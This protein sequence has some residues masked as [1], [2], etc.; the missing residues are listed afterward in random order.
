MTEYRQQAEGPP[1]ANRVLAPLGSRDNPLPF[2]IFKK[3][4]LCGEAPMAHYGIISKSV[5]QHKGQPLL[6]HRHSGT[7]CHGTWF[8]R[9]ALDVQTT[10]APVHGGAAAEMIW[11]W[12][13]VL[14]TSLGII[15]AIGVFFGLL[16]GG[17]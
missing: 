5:I 10:N 16:L 2:R 11:P 3:C 8:T 15:L 7:G 13:I 9:T 6:E 1:P 14:L 17:V 4:P 12:R